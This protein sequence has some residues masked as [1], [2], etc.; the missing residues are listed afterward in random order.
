MWKIDLVRK[1]LHIITEILF[2]LSCISCH[3]T[4]SAL[5][6]NC[7]IKLSPAKNDLPDWVH[8]LYTYKDPVVRASIWKLKY[9]H[10]HAF[11]EIYGTIIREY[12]LEQSSEDL[13]FGKR[14]PLYIIPVPLSPTRLRERGYNQASLIAQYVCTQENDTTYQLRDDIVHRKNTDTH[15]ARMKNKQQRLANI[16]GSFYIS[17]KELVTGKHVIIIDDVYTTGAT[18]GEMRRV[19][20]DAGV[21]SVFGITIAH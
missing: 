14:L 20:K 17:N 21:K 12:L 2:P 18:L 10:H 6:P 5:C 15:Q 1:W 19:L 4:G 16:R 9:R 11:A 8:A 13:L 3:A 7:L